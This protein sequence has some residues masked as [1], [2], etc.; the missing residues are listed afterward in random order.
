MA[1]IRTIKPELW[2]DEKLTECSRDARL[3]FVALLNFVDDM[4][5]K[6]YSPRRVRGEVFP[7]DD[8]V[9]DDVIVSLLREL[10]EQ[11]MVKLYTIDKVPYLWIVHF[12][13]HQRIDRPT[14]T[15]TPPYPLDRDAEC[16]CLGCRMERGEE[17]N[18]S[19]HVRTKRSVPVGTP[20]ALPESSTNR[21]ILDE[22]SGSAPTVVEGKGRDLKAFH[23]QSSSDLYIGGDSE[24]SD[25]STSPESSVSDRR[26]QEAALDQI[27]RSILAMIE[28][29]ANPLILD[30]LSS[31]IR[32][33]AKAHESSY[34]L[35]GQRVAARAASLVADETI[36]ENWQDW[37]QDVRYD[38]VAQ[39]D[40]TTRYSRLVCA[41]K[42]CSE[43]WETVRVGDLT[44][45]RRCPDC[46]R[47][48][49]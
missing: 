43:G 10:A 30:T 18:G 40:R 24:N 23:G 31:T 2:A 36:P 16:Q 41:G 48:W 32:F 21:R 34:E 42:R 45:L 6:Q 15:D 49:E 22:H 28:V 39:G 11:G 33:K 14:H 20:R 17:V 38:Y 37:L 1:R 26:T 5:R 7:L 47:L 9:D 25:S 44:V 12:L 19:K 35:A 8:D 27:A 13:R 29:P 4:G 3:L 46:V